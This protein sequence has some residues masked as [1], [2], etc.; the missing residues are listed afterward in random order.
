MENASK[1]LLLGAGILIGLI[2]ISIGV[3]LFST[4]S[5]N[6]SSVEKTMLANEI[7]KFNVN[8]TKFEG[9][10]NITIQEIVTLINFAKQYEEENGK[11]I[12]ISIAEKTDIINWLNTTIIVNSED[13]KIKLIEENSNK[14]FKC[15]NAKNQDIKYDDEGK[16]YHIKFTE[17]R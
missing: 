15:E 11:H 16:I 12:Q 13:K 10:N 14:I 5:E 6:T 2:V 1:A 17:K 3:Y 9:R 8:F 4:Y 7:Q